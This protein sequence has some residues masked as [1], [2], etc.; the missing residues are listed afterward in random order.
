VTPP[1]HTLRPRAPPLDPALPTP[2]KCLSPPTLLASQR[3]REEYQLPCTGSRQP[4]ARVLLTR[5]GGEDGGDP[6]RGRGRGSDPVPSKF[7]SPSVGSGRWYMEQPRGWTRPW[8][9]GARRGRR[10]GRPRAWGAGA[11]R[12]RAPDA[13]AAGELGFHGPMGRR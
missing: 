7:I 10:P 8:R 12:W 1:A 2:K 5:V 13:C 3:T 4:W 6:G 9:G 11:R